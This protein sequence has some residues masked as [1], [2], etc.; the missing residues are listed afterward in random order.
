MC[1]CRSMFG[2]ASI[3]HLDLSI[4]WPPDI[5]AQSSLCGLFWC[6]RQVFHTFQHRSKP[7]ACIHSNYKCSEPP[8]LEITYPTLMFLNKIGCQETVWWKFL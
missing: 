3:Y 6:I 5:P 1:N 2:A 4:S 7:I 8:F